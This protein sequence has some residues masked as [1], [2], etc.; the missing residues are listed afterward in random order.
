MPRLFFRYATAWMLGKAG[1]L[2]GREATTTAG[3]AW[4][5]RFQEFVPKATVVSNKRFVDAGK[6][7]TTAG[8]SSGIDGAL[9]V[10]EKLFGRGV[11]ED[12]ALKVEYNWQPDSKYVRAE[13]ADMNF[14]STYR[15]LLGEL[16][17]I[18]LK[19]A[20]S[21]DQWES[22]LVVA[23]TYT[24]SKLLAYIDSLLVNNQKWQ[25]LEL[26]TANDKAS[27]TWKFSD[28]SGKKWSGIVSVEKLENETDKHIVTINVARNN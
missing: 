10:I 9:H 27:S 12:V 15:E 11:A 3:S 1:L 4:N 25:R 13:L 2:D 8:L 16:K 6:I 26:K 7:V 21:F 18:P 28:K 22:N 17:A 14:N 24:A 19:T 23:K 5:G 20:G